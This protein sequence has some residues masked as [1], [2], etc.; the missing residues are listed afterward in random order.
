MV[1]ILKTD[2]IQA[3]H[4]NTIQI[5]S[6]H[7]LAQAGSIINFAKT[8]TNTAVVFAN[9]ST[10]TTFLSLT[11]TPK[12]ANSLLLVDMSCS[13][14]SKT[15]AGAGWIGIRIDLDD[16]SSDT[17]SGAFMYPTATNDTR[18]PFHSRA[19]INS[20]GTTQK[21]VAFKTYGAGTT[22]S[23]SHQNTE[24]SLTVMEVVQ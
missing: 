9:N 18:Q 2:K 15:T 14:V 16:V 12:F 20:W 24:S 17:M 1:S 4:G 10:F 11:Y 3:S 8:E 19:I 6:G 5:P 13:S 23:W 22:V 7:T 21:T